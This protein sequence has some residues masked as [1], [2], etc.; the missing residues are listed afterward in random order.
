METQAVNVQYEAT[1][2]TM[3][4]KKKRKM[5]YLILKTQSTLHENL[6]YKK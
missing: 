6:Y 1:F 4:N 5:N 2:T 3:K